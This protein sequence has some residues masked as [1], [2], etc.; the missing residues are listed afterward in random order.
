MKYAINEKDEFCGF[1]WETNEGYEVTDSM[2][3]QIQDLVKSVTGETMSM[4]QVLRMIDLFKSG[5]IAD[6]VGTK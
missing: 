1:I 5:A 4:T 6:L 3:M 2:F